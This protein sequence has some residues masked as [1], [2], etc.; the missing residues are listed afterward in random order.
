[1]FARYLRLRFTPSHCVFPNLISSH[2]LKYPLGRNIPTSMM[3][4]TLTPHTNNGVVVDEK[5]TSTFSLTFAKLKALKL[6]SDKFLDQP[7][8]VARKQATDVS[9]TSHVAMKEENS[10]ASTSRNDND[11]SDDCLDDGCTRP[12]M[13]RPEYIAFY[14]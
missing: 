14:K 10:L 6:G 3:S 12:A 11:P 8:V 9:P 2:P 5:V 13:P 7:T 4:S 1:M